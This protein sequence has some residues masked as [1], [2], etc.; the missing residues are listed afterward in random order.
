MYSNIKLKYSS[1]IPHLLIIII[2][3]IKLQK[4]FVD[5]IKLKRLFSNSETMKECSGNDIDYKNMEIKGK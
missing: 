4:G 2:Y 1:F 5:S 3:I